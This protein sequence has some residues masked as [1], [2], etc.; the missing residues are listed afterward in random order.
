MNNTYINAYID[1]YTRRLSSSNLK[2][3]LAVL[4]IFDIFDF[5]IAKSLGNNFLLGIVAVVSLFEVIYFLNAMKKST[6]TIY[7][8]VV[9]GIIFYLGIV[10][11]MNITLYVEQKQTD[12][13]DIV[14]FVIILTTQLL[15]LLFGFWYSIKR[16]KKGVSFNPYLGSAFPLASVVGVN[17]LINRIMKSIKKTNNV[18][19]ESLFFTIILTGCS[20]GMMYLTGMAYITIIYCI[21]KY[22]IPDR[23]IDQNL[24]N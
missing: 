14:S 3:L 19:L 16:L 9:S 12:T 18:I 2:K 24:S 4:L 20:A 6:Q 21:K 13:F 5:I 17:M 1:K 15:C 7:S 11:I 23:E 10:F 8:A 22:K